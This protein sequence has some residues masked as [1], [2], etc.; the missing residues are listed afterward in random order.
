MRPETW[1][2]WKRTPRV[3]G[4]ARTP[5]IG[6]QI[7]AQIVARIGAQIGVAALLGL[8]IG[9]CADTPT[10][11]SLKA[12]VMPKSGPVWARDLANGLALQEWELCEELGSYDCVSDA[13]R[14][15]L[16]GVEAAN[17]GIDA[18]LPNAAVSAPMAAERV[19]IAACTERLDRDMA[20]PAVIFGPILENNNGSNNRRRREEVSHSLVER[21][22]GRRA[23]D[24]DIDALDQ[25]Y[26][27][28][29][30]IST[31]PSHDWAVGACVVLATSTEA[32]FY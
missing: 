30:P 20:G 29:E 22:L 23:T 4:G 18:P 27:T 21:L 17:L 12:R 26:D 6:A 28:L 32:L 9:G 19:A 5:S 13:H 16:G 11:V 7:G 14:I 31:R 10:S 24:A 2:T 15:V 8:L 3:G 25:L 1:L